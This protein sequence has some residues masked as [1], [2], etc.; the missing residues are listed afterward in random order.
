VGAVDVLVN[1]AA[2]LLF[3]NEDVLS[4]PPT[5]YRDMFDTNVIGM[6]ESS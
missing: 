2:L 4:I 1:N 6:R 3:E 5:G